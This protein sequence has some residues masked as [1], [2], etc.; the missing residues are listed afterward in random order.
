M[1][2]KII[3]LLIL[4]MSLVT[5]ASAQNRPGK[6]THVYIKGGLN[7]SNAMDMKPNAADKDFKPGFNVGLQFDTKLDRHFYFQSGIFF[8]TKGGEFNYKG[9]KE[10]TEI[11]QM[12]LQIPLAFAY[13]LHLE[14]KTHLVFNFGSYIAYGIAGKIDDGSHKKRDTFDKT[15][16]KRFDVGLL[17]GIGLEVDRVLLGVNYEYG[18]LNIAQAKKDSYKNQNISISLGFKF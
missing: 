3:F 8:T 13:K 18:L 10:Q 15:G 1:R 7:L 14:R 16:L 4:S 6:T 11:N 12:Y 17:G 2:T 5:T 9:N